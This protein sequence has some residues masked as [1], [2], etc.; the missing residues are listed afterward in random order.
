MLLNPDVDLGAVMDLENDPDIADQDS[1]HTLPLWSMPLVNP[2]LRRARLIKNVRLETRLELFS[3]DGG[4]SG[5][6]EIEM[7]PKFYNGGPEMKN[8]LKLLRQLAKLPAY[9]CYTLRRGLREFGITV[10]D[11]AVLNLS[12]VKQN[13]LFPFMQSLTRPLMRHLYGGAGNGLTTTEGLIQALSKTD[14]AATLT[15]IEEMSRALGVRPNKLPNLLED[16]GDAFL[17]LSYYRSFFNKALPKILE[18]KEWIKVAEASRF[19]RQSPALNQA[20]RRSVRNL[21]Q[22][23]QGINK[24]FIKFDTYIVIDWN[25]ISIKQFDRLRKTII[26]HHASMAEVLCGLTV[27][28]LEWEAAF[29]NRGG[30]PERRC[31]FI[32][33]GFCDGLE[34][35]AEIEQTAPA[36]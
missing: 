2:A 17:S 23:E 13:E 21:H 32:S 28:I 6:I 27:K 25:N 7:A 26:E 15:R 8:D 4:G 5:Q 10:A 19:A 1:L 20:I 9:D 18:I 11:E 30:G 35:L 12:E 36:L 3:D 31:D 22:L 29:P 34:R 16:L 14:N 33:G 24:R